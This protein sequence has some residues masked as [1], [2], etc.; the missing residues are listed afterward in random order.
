MTQ[1]INNF[2]D[3]KLI[4]S[5]EKINEQIIIL[6]T[7]IDKLVPSLNKVAETQSK[8]GKETKDTATDTKKLTA[9]EKEAVRIAKSLE[10]TEAKINGLRTKSGKLLIEK[11]VA[12]QKDTAETKR[13][14]ASKNALT[15]SYIKI[16]AE[17]NKNVA[18]YKAL[19]AEQRN[20]TKVGGQLLSTIKKQDA[21]L[22]RLDSSM[23]R[24]N[25]NVGRSRSRHETIRRLYEKEIF[26]T[27]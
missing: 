26:C 2:I 18:R 25:R 27:Y 9:A 6:G 10:T 11:K 7:N 8:L 1:D 24:S 15:G 14:V 4:T 22:K 13:N 3:P 16:N 5:L 23:G 20:N 19:S 17:L 12:L 21:A